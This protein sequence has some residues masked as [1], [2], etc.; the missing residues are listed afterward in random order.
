MRARDQREIAA[1]R[2]RIRGLDRPGDEVAARYRARAAAY[3]LRLADLDRR[4][5]DGLARCD[6][7]VV[8]TAHQEGNTG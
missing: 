5:R 8:V 6:R 2:V 3:R 1:P 4:Y 7:R